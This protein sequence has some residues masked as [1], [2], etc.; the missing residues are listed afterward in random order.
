MYTTRWCGFCVRAKTLLDSR[1]LPYEEISLDDDPAFRQ[2]V[3]DVTGGWTVPADPRRRPADRRLHRALAPRPRRSSRRAPRR[4]IRLRRL[5][6]RTER[7]RPAGD[8]R[9]RDRRPAAVARLV[10]ASVDAELVLHR[11]AARTAG[12]VVERRACRARPSR[13]PCGSPRCSRRSSSRVELARRPLR[14]EPRVPERL[15]GVDVPEP[16][17]RPL[18]ED[19]GLERVRRPPGARRAARRREERVERL[20]ADAGGEVRLGVLG[21]EQQPRPEPSGVAVCDVRSVVELENGT[22]V[23]V[24]RERPVPSASRLP[25]IRR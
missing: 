25:V 12:V 20:V 21:V 8:L 14:V 22:A 19:R 2:T 9:A 17:D 11:A 10:A 7:R 5:A 1:G 18:V 6:R 23:R 3:F 16:G 4:L 15:V 24:V 13:A